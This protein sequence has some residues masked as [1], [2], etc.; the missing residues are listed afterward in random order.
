[1]EDEKEDKL[2]VPPDEDI[3]KDYSQE[4]IKNMIN[5]V[6]YSDIKSL[7]NHLKAIEISLKIFWGNNILV[8]EYKTFLKKLKAKKIV[9]F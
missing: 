8:E 9:N 6:I 2:N 1:M 4:E 3:N 5:Q 7:N